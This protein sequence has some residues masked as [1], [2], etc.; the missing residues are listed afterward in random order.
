MVLRVTNP[1]AVIDVRAAEQVSTVYDAAVLGSGVYLG[2][3]LESACLL[4]DSHAEALSRIP[5]WLFSSGPI[6]DLPMPR[7]I[8]WT[9]RP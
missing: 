1:D 5:V 6:G 3:W 7:R 2:H 9:S 4:V 8:R